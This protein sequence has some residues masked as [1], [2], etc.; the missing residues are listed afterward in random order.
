MFNVDWMKSEIMKSHTGHSNPCLKP[1]AISKL[2][3]I[4]SKKKYGPDD[5]VN[6]R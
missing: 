6:V 1:F 5:H 3:G 4:G 2:K